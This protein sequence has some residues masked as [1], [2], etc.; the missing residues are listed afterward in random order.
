MAFE[1]PV[2]IITH[3]VKPST[4]PL[5]LMLGGR[6]Q[7]LEGWTNV[8]LHEGQNVDIRADISD[9]RAVCRDGSV[10]ELYCSHCLEHFPHPRTLSVLKEW[11][12]VLQPGGQIYISVPDFDAMV[13]LYNKMGVLVPLIR[14]MLCG[15]QGYDLAFHY[16]LFT[17]ATLAALCVEAGF[18][19]VKRLDRMPYG[20]LDC[21]ALVDTVTDMPISLSIKAIR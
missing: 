5:R 14:N 15:D 19:D 8:D 13:K 16:N 3:E 17:Y 9:L 12:R 1:A 18:R 10:L 4:G 11:Y 20:L 2:E 6:D 21:S 7:R